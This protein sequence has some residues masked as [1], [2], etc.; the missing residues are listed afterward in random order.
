MAQS[1]RASMREGPLAALFSKTEEEERAAE[2]EQAPSEG[3]RRSAPSK[4]PGQPPA[5]EPERPA[6]GSPRSP[7]R[8]TIL[9]ACRRWSRR[10][11]P[12]PIPSPRERLRNVFSAEIPANMMERPAPATTAA[13]EPPPVDVYARE[14]PRRPTRATPVGSR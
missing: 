14:E 2:S 12:P 8:R 1:K 9:R 10:R 4:K 7:P 13:K 6:R 3:A 5:R 11:S